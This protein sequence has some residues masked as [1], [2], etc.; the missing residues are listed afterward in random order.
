MI[1][2][3]EN[4]QEENVI[5]DFT[6]L[7]NQKAYSYPSLLF[8][9]GKD[10]DG[11][12]QIYIFA[13]FDRILETYEKI[14][15][16]NENTKKITEYFDKKYSLEY[17][18]QKYNNIEF[19]ELQD[20]LEFFMAT[21]QTGLIYKKTA[22]DSSFDKQMLQRFSKSINY[23]NAFKKCFSSYEDKINFFN[24]SICLSEKILIVSL[25]T[26]KYID[27]IKNF[28]TEKEKKFLWLILNSIVKTAVLNDLYEL[29]PF[30]INKSVIGLKYEKVTFAQFNKLI[31]IFF[32]NIFTMEKNTYEI[33]QKYFKYLKYFNE[34]KEIP[35]P[36]TKDDKKIW[37]LIEYMI[38]DRLVNKENSLV[39]KIE[40][41]SKNILEKEEKNIE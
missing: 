27:S 29:A 11:N 21:G 4:F 13:Y 41:I 22:E 34:R 18:C 40:E 3:F 10:F 39:L 36:L 16:I 17:V 31:C 26:N 33:F 6:S 32:K 19:K 35:S 2:L 30:H 5:L 14:P 12:F 8:Y 15:Y 24:I 25:N 7:Q 20:F 1:N 28:D 37:D 38:V 23:I 9:K